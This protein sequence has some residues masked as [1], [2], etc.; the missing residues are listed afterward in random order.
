MKFISI[1]NWQKIGLVC[2]L[3]IL[4]QF[5]MALPVCEDIFQDP[6]SENLRPPKI[7]V[8]P[9]NMPNLGYAVCNG[10]SSN[11]LKCYNNQVSYDH[12][13]KF[14]PANYNYDSSTS[15]FDDIKT[16]YTQGK[17]TRLYFRDLKLDNAEF[18]PKGNEANLIVYVR[19]NL[20][21]LGKSKINGIVYVQGSVTLS[22]D[23]EIE[24][25]LAAEGTITSTN[26]N[27]DFEDDAIED[28]DFGEMCQHKDDE[29]TPVES[30]L[31]FKYGQARVVDKNFHVDGG[32][33]TIH[34]VTYR[35][36]FPKNVTPL[37]FLMPTINLTKPNEPSTLVL[38]EVTNTGFKW[39]QVVPPPKQSNAIPSD[40]IIE[41]VNWVAINPGLHYFNQ[42]NRQ[43]KIVKNIKV[44]AGIEKTDEAIWQNE[45]DEYE[46]TK[47]DSKLKVVLSQIQPRPLGQPSNNCWLTSLAMF[48]KKEKNELLIGADASE[49]E[50]SGICKPGNYD[51]E[52]LKYKESL[53]YLAVEPGFGTLLLS[54]GD[55]LK[56]QFGLGTT[57]TT[58]NLS[59]LAD[60]CEHKTSFQPQLFIHPPILVAGKNSRNGVEGGWLRQCSLTSQNVGTVV[61][62][63]NYKTSN[64]E[65]V[66]ENF[67]YVAFEP[68]NECFFDDFNRPALGK[69]WISKQ[70][71]GSLSPEIVDELRLRL[72][73]DKEKQ[74]AS[75]TL[76][77]LF[78][79]EG[80]KL[81]IEFN[82]YSWRESDKTG[83]DGIAVILSD[84]NI[85]P[86]PGGFG[87]AMGYTPFETKDGNGKDIKYQGF[88]GGWLG[89][90]LD[91]TGN[92][93]NS[94]DGNKGGGGFKT[95]PQ[96]IAMRG[97]ET[98]AYKY[99][100]TSNKL[101]PTLDVGGVKTPQTGDRY[102]I[103]LDS[104]LSGEFFVTVERKQK[105][106]GFETIIPA[107]DIRKLQNQNPL[108]K[109]FYLTFTGAT[110]GLSNNHELDNL[111]VCSIKKINPIG[112]QVHHFEFHYSGDPL[113][114]GP[115]DVTIKACKNKQCDPF[116]IP[117][118]AD[119]K[120]TNSKGIQWLNN[121]QQKIT[122][123]HFTKKDKGILHLK[124]RQ[125]N[126]NSPITLG[127]SH[128]SLKYQPYAGKTLCSRDGNPVNENDCKVT[129]AESGFWI[130]YL[131]DKG[132]VMP[133][134]Q[135]YANKSITATISAVKAITQNGKNPECAPFW[136]GETKSVGLWGT[137]TAPYSGKGLYFNDD[138]KPLP[139][140]EYAAEPKLLTFN[141]NGKTQIQLRYPD[142]GNPS[143][144]A[145]YQGKAE[146]KDH[147]ENLIM[148]SANGDF[149]SV[150]F[151]F[152]VS[153]KKGSNECDSQNANC[154]AFEIAGKN[155][156]LSVS[157]VAWNNNGID[158][159]PSNITP[160]FKMGSVPL[161]G[162]LIAPKSGIQGKLTTYDYNHQLG[163]ETQISQ[164]NSEVG[165][166]KFS[167]GWQQN[168]SSGYLG[169]TLTIHQGWTP[170]LRFIP[171]KFV[172]TGNISPACDVF[173]Y[174]KQP[175]QLSNFS[176]KAVNT[177]NQLTK[178]Y[179]DS[180]A[181]SNNNIF[182]VAENDDDG[183]NRGSRI[184]HGIQD[185][186][187]H[188]Q[189]MSLNAT[190]QFNRLDKPN[191]DGPY[192][193]LSIGLNI[194]D[195]DY[196]KIDSA[197][198]N[199]STLGD[200]N[201]TNTC[202]AK[203][204]G[205][206]AIR[207][208]RIM[209]DNVYGP[210]TETL[211]MPT[212]AQYWAG[213]TLKWQTNTLDS[214]TTFGIHNGEINPELTSQEENDD[215][216]KFEPS[217]DTTKN[218][219]VTRSGTGNFISGKFDLMW[220]SLGN[221]QYKGK[222][223]APLKVPEW[224]KFYWQWPSQVEDNQNPRASAYFGS[225]RGND[226]IIYW[227][228]LN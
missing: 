196:V 145:I 117:V 162:Q 223:T 123:A 155:F 153:P 61:D 198:L 187:K 141:K 54:T 68:L 23:S 19:G 225:Y 171:A 90:A 40:E 16:F 83:A 31:L 124:L 150:P 51:L 74:A 112:P 6:P 177:N 92:F 13:I 119:L 159:N 138:K 56:F 193:N 139:N 8:P 128:A 184:T 160:S 73:K 77:K 216:Y 210:E 140:S 30:N 43:G 208:G 38:T 179:N 2:L 186:W 24:G 201:V 87:G 191:I 213:N 91:E 27:Y 142:A 14:Q 60:Q 66:K 203:S 26:H 197:D 172:V 71:A 47:V 20:A 137:F 217:I 188:G 52:D 161:E 21:M 120:P 167:A 121:Q 44:Q 107:M 50:N 135:T 15:S 114:C 204:L 113:T 41:T 109:N 101:D 18:N 182:V 46:Y 93:S 57:S 148:K 58:N 70:L 122:Q 133:L 48:D 181:K 118:T 10:N 49:V 168:I 98:T 136:G 185:K 86:E 189:L 100:Y 102:R 116:I 22:Y 34:W 53:A 156:P 219:S 5:A 55:K 183:I 88:S 163:N 202:N 126:A 62:E 111:S 152:C 134:S 72:T 218:Q 149:I 175:F 9:T 194:N 131:D 130:D 228:E 80:N 1:Q 82:Y 106:Q 78:P 190:M 97:S 81:V 169:S 65:H 115:L 212:Y 89:I 224:L 192:D 4:P 12:K 221:P 146:E 205:T 32:N 96:T 85:T 227:R 147:D 25:G 206:Q 105:G 28:A 144:H 79:A 11:L 67:S 158:C 76:N 170:P 63:D 36:P 75:I 214:C 132:N 200:C 59:S 157:A 29:K 103:T 104:K 94:N 164:S 180:F 39:K 69:D 178:N 143:L 35:E 33:T 174:M 125:N 64:R 207:F 127:V 166:F 209:M 3:A 151:G 110:G 7:L 165:V 173:S 45:P 195:A 37:V 42:I 108:P 199:A 154:P 176:A 17:T 220:Q 129:F 222:I 215:G 95:L 99:L 211:K 226:R 84:S